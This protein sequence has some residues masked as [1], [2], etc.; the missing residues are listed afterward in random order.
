ME[1]SL[2]GVIDAAHQHL[3]VSLVLLP[4]GEFAAVVVAAGCVVAD[5]GDRSDVERMV[6]LAVP[7][8]VES[9]AVVIT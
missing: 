4:A 9:V 7:G 6:Q 8:P 2:G 5:L 3:N 1:L